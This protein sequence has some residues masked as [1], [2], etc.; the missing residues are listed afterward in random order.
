MVLSEMTLRNIIEDNL[1]IQE[2]NDNV[3]IVWIKD[4]MKS[5]SEVKPLIMCKEAGKIKI[6]T[7]SLT[8]KEEEFKRESS[9]R[10]L[11]NKEDAVIAILGRKNGELFLSE[12]FEMNYCQQGMPPEVENDFRSLAFRTYFPDHSLELPG[13]KVMRKVK[14]GQGDK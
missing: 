6:Y 12:I 4:S 14:E 3:Y 11:V 5:S 8:L 1:L 10:L 2:V 13:Y 7:P 9:E